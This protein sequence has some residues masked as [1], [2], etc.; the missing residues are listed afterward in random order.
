M[1]LMLLMLLLLLWLKHPNRPLLL[2]AVQLL[3]TLLSVL[4][5]HVQN[6]GRP[7]HKVSC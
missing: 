7:S 5:Q 6:T 2:A 3:L 4:V 1:W